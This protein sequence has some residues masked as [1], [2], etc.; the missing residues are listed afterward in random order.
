M[1]ERH[2]EPR[3]ARVQQL[4]ELEER[5]EVLARSMLADADGHESALGA[6]TDHLLGLHLGVE[7]FGR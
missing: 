2:D 1:Y 4:G 3:V 6:G 5:V 7:L